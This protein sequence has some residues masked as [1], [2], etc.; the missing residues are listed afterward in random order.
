MT[1]FPKARWQSHFRWGRWDYWLQSHE[2]T[3]LE[4]YP[5]IQLMHQEVRVM[6][7]ILAWAWGKQ[8]SIRK[9]RVVLDTHTVFKAWNT[10]F[11]GSQV[12]FIGTWNIKKLHQLTL[13]VWDCSSA[14]EYQMCLPWKEVEKRDTF[15]FIS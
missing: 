11:R 3:K 12:A 5:E 9:T 7:L 2:N 15:I 6:L 8:K 1:Q 4:W 13:F 10:V 14:S